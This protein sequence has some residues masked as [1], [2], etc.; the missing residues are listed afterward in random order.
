MV[1]VTAGRRGG[2]RQ[3]ALEAGTP[4][5]SLEQCGAELDCKADSQWARGQRHEEL[6]QTFVQSASLKCDKGPHNCDTFP[7]F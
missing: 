3:A 2:R 4:G 6:I 5:P 1:V 7:V